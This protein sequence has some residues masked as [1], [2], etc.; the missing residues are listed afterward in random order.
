MSR[1]E[2]KRKVGLFSFMLLICKI[3]NDFVPG[4]L[5]TEEFVP[6]IFAPALVPG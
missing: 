3:E 1:K 5:G 6:G 4:R 2:A